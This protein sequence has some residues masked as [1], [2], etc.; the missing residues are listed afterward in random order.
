M[1]LAAVK[2]AFEPEVLKKA[3]EE[4]MKSTGGKYVSAVPPEIKPNV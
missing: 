2:A 1:A 3:K 4:L